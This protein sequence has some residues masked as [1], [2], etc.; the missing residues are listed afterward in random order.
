MQGTY[1][2]KLVDGHGELLFGG[3]VEPTHARTRARM[4]SHSLPCFA[5]A[6]TLIARA[7]LTSFHV[8][9]SLPS[10][11]SQKITVDEAYVVKIPTSLPLARAAPLLCAGITM[12]SPLKYFTR[13]RDPATMRVGI[14]GFGGLGHMGVKVSI[15]LAR[16][17]MRP[18][19]VRVVRCSFPSHTHTPEPPPRTF[20]PTTQPNIHNHPQ[21]AQHTKPHKNAC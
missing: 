21:H 15:E 10:R 14:Q 19:C 7:L 5:F 9:S 12:W 16:P 8:P 2:C 17:H 6:D 20:T 11:Y 1:N 4:R 13:N 18:Q 3:Y